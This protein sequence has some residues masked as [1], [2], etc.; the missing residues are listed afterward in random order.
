MSS[1]FVRYICFLGTIGGMLSTTARQI[2]QHGRD[3][4]QWSNNTKSQGPELITSSANSMTDLS[5]MEPWTSQRSAITQ[6]TS[7]LSTFPRYSMS[8]SRISSIS[9]AR[10][11]HGGSTAQPSAYAISVGPVTYPSRTAMST[12]SEDTGFTR[13]TLIVTSSST[14]NSPGT[15][16]TPTSQQSFLGSDVQGYVPSYSV[17]NTDVASMAKTTNGGSYMTPMAF[18]KHRN[19]SPHLPAEITVVT[20]QNSESTIQSIPESAGDSLSGLQPTTS[21][22][23]NHITQPSAGSNRVQN[24]SG[25][26]SPSAGSSVSLADTAAPG[27]SSLDIDQVS[28]A[29]LVLGLTISNVGARPTASTKDGD[30]S[31]GDIILGGSYTTDASA[32]KNTTPISTFQTYWPTVLSTGSSPGSIESIHPATYSHTGRPALIDSSRT[33]SP[34]SSHLPLQAAQMTVA[35]LRRSSLDDVLTSSDSSTVTGQTYEGAISPLAIATEFAKQDRVELGTSTGFQSHTGSGIKMKLATEESALRSS[36]N[37]TT[38]ASLKSV[39]SVTQSHTTSRRSTLSTSSAGYVSYITTV[40]TSTV[41]AGDIMATSSTSASSVVGDTSESH[42]VL[43]NSIEVAGGTVAGGACIF[44]AILAWAR[45]L[46]KRRGII[47]IDHSSRQDQYQ[48]DP[49]RSYFSADS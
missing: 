21:E 32:L 13:S 36:S 14:S 20:P 5:Y 18:T 23:T 16:E 33:R 37:G 7:D 17:P 42:K 2:H 31:M 1:V 34:V 29:S 30:P 22:V 48:R 43:K 11:D 24:E 38:T 12:T 19:T 35:S 27:T 9:E 15:V 6:P 41:V 47:W 28:T 46:R 49:C 40:I 44:I 8:P 26:E 39:V 45:H 25:A 3:V 10:A 4:I